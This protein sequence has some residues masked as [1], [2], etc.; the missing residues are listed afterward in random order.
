MKKSLIPAAVLALVAAPLLSVVPAH[1]GSD[2]VTICHA[3]SAANGH[4]NQIEVAKDATAGGHANHLDAAD[5]IP[6]YNWVDKGVRY[7]FDGQNTDKLDIL[8]AGCMAPAEQVVAAP[9]KPV[10]VP[11]SCARPEEPF[12][13]VVIPKDLGAGVAGA[14]SALSPD[15]AKFSVTYA[16][17]APTEERVYSWPA[18]VTGNW[19][20]TAVPIT[21]DPLYVIDSKTG[22]GQC[23][24]SNTGAVMTA[25]PYA[26]GATG[27]GTLI[28][29]ASKIRRRKEVK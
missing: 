16:L 13:R 5:I 2:K 18:G 25:L 4:W 29:A 19:E 20:F 15:N 3:T 1:A 26:V 8:A 11:A 7:Y 22:K 17:A 10:Y 28:F 24:L 12:G 23:E 14:S 21:Q 9:N 27:V 6:A